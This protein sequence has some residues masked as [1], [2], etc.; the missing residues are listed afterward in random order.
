MSE[1]DATAD[2]CC[3]Y[4]GG[5]A[6]GARKFYTMVSIAPDGSRHDG[7]LCSECVRTVIIDLAV[8][9]RE[10]FD[11]LIEEAR[12]FAAGVRR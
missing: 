1:H 5:R 12:T 4:C 2:L 10:T 9:H 6:D 7:Q 3:G 11:S 8:S